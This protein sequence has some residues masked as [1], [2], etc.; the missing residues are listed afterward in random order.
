MGEGVLIIGY[1][2]WL[3]GDDAAG[4]LAARR[5]A[6]RGFDAVDVHQLTPELAERVASAG[7]VVF[8]D[9][10]AGVAPGAVSVRPVTPGAAVMEHVGSPGGLLRLARVAY[11]AEP[12]AWMIGMGGEDFGVGEGVSAAAEMAMGRAIEAAMQCVTRAR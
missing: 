11:G 10:D 1:G 8:L 4:R 9:A 3:R 5:L 7:T 6:E 2:S 12:K